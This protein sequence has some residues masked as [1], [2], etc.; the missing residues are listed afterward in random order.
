[1]FTGEVLRHTTISTELWTWNHCSST[2]ANDA[3]RRSGARSLSRLIASIISAADLAK[4][5]A[6]SLKKYKPESFSL[7]KLSIFF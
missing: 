5:I 2:I 7:F 6:K 4:T 1:M 3:R